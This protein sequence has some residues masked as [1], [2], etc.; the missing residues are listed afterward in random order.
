MAALDL[1]NMGLN[2]IDVDL[3]TNAG[4]TGIFDRLMAAVSANITTQYTENRINSE[5]FATIYLGSMQSV[6][7]QSMQFALQEQLVEAQIAGVL[8]DNTL[9]AKQLQV[10]TLEETIKQ[11][12]VTSMLPEHLIKIQE[13]ID[14]IQ[15]Q[16]SETLLDGVKKRLAMDE[17]LLS[18]KKN[19]E[20]S[21][22]ELAN[23][24][25]EQLIKIQEEIDLIQTQDSE[26]IAD[27]LKKRLLLDEQLR[28]AFTDRV[29]KD[30][31]AAKLGL[32]N[33]MKLSE[34]SRASNANFV[35]LPSYIAAV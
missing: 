5:D 34:A 20:I 9:K 14:L 4:S 28:G 19:L 18:K 7:S 16:D 12:E 6:L 8:A 10:A 27:G 26:V 29:L 30:K 33:V 13:E 1:S 15:T 23:L 3:I 21:T 31:Q 35:Y 22:Y 32:D 2:D 24:L 11:F 17:D 25:P